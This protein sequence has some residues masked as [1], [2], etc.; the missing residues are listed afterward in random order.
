MS[1]TCNA[2]PSNGAY[3]HSAHPMADGSTDE[4]TVIPDCL[5]AAASIKGVWRQEAPKRVSPQPMAASPNGDLCIP[6]RRPPTPSWSAIGVTRE[7]ARP[8]QPS[9][10]YG[11]Q[12]D[13]RNVYPVPE[14]GPAVDTPHGLGA[15]P[16][17]LKQSVVPGLPQYHFKGREIKLSHLLSLNLIPFQVLGW[18]HESTTNSADASKRPDYQP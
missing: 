16:H 4:E 6:K 2:S 17:P 12:K 15:H 1:F 10:A 8:R 7:E 13:R 5:L 9:Q 18:R 14:D 3:P 11:L